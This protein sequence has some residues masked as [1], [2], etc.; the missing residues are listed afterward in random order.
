[1]T[2]QCLCKLDQPPAH[3]TTHHQFAGQDEIGQCEQTEGINCREHFPWELDGCEFWHG[4]NTAQ[5]HDADR[6][7][8]GHA[9]KNQRE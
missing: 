5:R 7:Y 8:H 1:V 9:Q 4:K 3:A 2:H 6:E